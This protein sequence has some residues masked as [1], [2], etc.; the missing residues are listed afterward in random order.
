VV[1]AGILRGVLCY[2]VVVKHEDMPA[3]GRSAPPQGAMVGVVYCYPSAPSALLVVTSPCPHAP[4]LP[5]KADRHH[6]AT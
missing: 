3:W 6:N 1:Y 2:G 4:M 5:S